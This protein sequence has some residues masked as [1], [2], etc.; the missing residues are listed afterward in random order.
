MGLAADLGYA[1][2]RPSRFQRLVQ[3]F[4][5]SRVGGALT[6]RTLVPLDRIV[7]RL[8][9]GR[10]SLPLAL[11]GL[12]VLDLVTVGAKSGLPRPT[13]VI[14]VPFED[15]LALLGTNFG[16]PRTPAW[17]VNLEHHPRA[18][19]GY[20]GATRPVV[21]RP[22]AADERARITQEAAVVFAG[23]AAY[24]RRAEGAR[25]VRVFVLEPG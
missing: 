6:P 20:A 17:V 2:P 13:H 14:A 7:D 10:V 23:T 19:V 18:T 12:P 3:A 1:Y 25:R 11:A 22:A 16:Q 8:T 5:A 4:A 9:R 15:T 21:A 24:E